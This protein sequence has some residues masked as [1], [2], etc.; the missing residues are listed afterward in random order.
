MTH[1]AYEQQCPW[2]DFAFPV[3][4]GSLWLK[5]GEAFSKCQHLAGSP[6]P[7]AVAKDLAGIFLAKGALA[8]TAIEGNTLSEEQAKA[9]LAQQL[10]LPPSQQYL[11][12]ELHNVAAALTDIDH[13]A[14]SANTLHLTPEWIKEQNRIILRDLEL[15]DHVIPGEYTETQLVVGDY[16][17]APPEDVDYLVDRLCDWLNHEWLA[18]M[19]DESTGPDMKFVYAFFAATLAHL[20]IAWIHPFG[21]GNGRTARLLECSILAHCGVVPWVSSNVLSDFYNRT[22]S[23]P[24]SV[25]VILGSSVWE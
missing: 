14:V 21:D 2:I 22:R 4:L 16:R 13:S 17:A 15:E 10:H 23:K 7:P 3:E 19:H 1:R 5:L 12:Q 8:T 24:E 9:I 25:E 11:E 20:Y 18:P 6:L